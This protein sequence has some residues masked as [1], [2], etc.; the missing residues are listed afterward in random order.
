MN[1]TIVA[2]ATPAGVGGIAVVR[3]SGSEA[4]A[5][6]FGLVA[7]GAREGSLFSTQSK[8]AGCASFVPR[9]ATY[10]Q[11]F[12]DGEL[13]DDAVVTYFEAPHSYTGE[14]CVEISCHGSQYVQQRLLDV[15]VAAGAR[16]ADPG[17]FTMRAFL[18][19]RMDL[20]QA[21]AVADLVDATTLGAHRLASRQLRGQVASKLAELR[22][23]FVRLASLME[24]ELDFSEEEV[25]F[26][27]RSQLLQLLDE[28]EQS[29][30]PLAD[31]FRMG[32][33]VK[34]GI[35]VAI[36]GHPNVG[37][38]TLLNALVGDDRA[39]VSP[40]PGTTR[41]TIEECVTIEG[42]L[43]RFVDTAGLRHSGD[44]IEQAGMERS[45]K[46]VQ[47]ADT[48]LVVS[49]NPETPLPELPAELLADK[50]VVYLL[51]KADLLPQIPAKADGTI[52]APMAISAKQGTGLDSLRKALAA[53]YLATQSPDRAVLTNVRHHQ[54]LLSTLKAVENIREGLASNRPTDLVVVDIR[55]ALYHIGSI[56]GQVTDSEILHSIFANFCIGK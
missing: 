55:D 3:L 47:Q 31:S 46:A 40:T 37:K 19:G 49:D 24:L 15:L 33:A 12:A 2:V 21:E 22:E 13:L 29:A 52:D 34:S 10:V 4:R 36:A 23:R 6:A 32:N 50:Q 45:R 44:A 35:R 28:I 11:L 38:S 18:N 16:L 25:E 8:K 20:S 51:N 56:T 1:D 30:R 48:V 17:E 43:F 9:R 14:D 26:A 27:D 41:D 53:P 39:I 54:A 7:P 5:L 42:L